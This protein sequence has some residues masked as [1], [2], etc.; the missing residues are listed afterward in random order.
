[1]NQNFENSHS[2]QANLY[3][4][5]IDT[6][7]D[8]IPSMHDNDDRF[9]IKWDNYYKYCYAPFIKPGNHINSQLKCSQMS[10]L[11]IMWEGTVISVEISSL[12][13]NLEQ[14][15]TTYLPE[16]LTDLVFCWYG[17]SNEA[18]DGI[19]VSDFDEMKTVL[20]QRRK[21]NLN[22]W[23]TYT[24]NIK[25]NMNSGLLA[26]PTEVVLKASHAFNNFTKYLHESDRI[27]FKGTLLK[28]SKVNPNIGGSHSWRSELISN[29]PLVDIMAVGCIRCTHSKMEDVTV[30]SNSFKLNER[31]KDLRSGFKYLLNVLFNPVIIFK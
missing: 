18:V 31:I 19:H 7:T 29:E 26:K 27:W 13:N 21:C 2:S 4:A 14:L 17:E 6:G 28:N 23:N 24:F 20:K 11:G 25:V 5:I 9:P 1:M 8:S 16:F 12:E 22:S 15:I 3:G 30:V 10:G